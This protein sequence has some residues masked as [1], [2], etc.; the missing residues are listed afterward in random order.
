M[1]PIIVIPPKK[2]RKIN[3]SLDD[4]VKNDS[5]APLFKS[6]LYDLLKRKR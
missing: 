3:Y 5:S 4:F 6:S 2:R 1:P